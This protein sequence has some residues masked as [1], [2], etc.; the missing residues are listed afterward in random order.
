MGLLD[1]SRGGTGSREGS[2]SLLFAMPTHHI[3]AE[4]R[5]WSL[6]L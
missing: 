4:P 3:Q 1:C 6:R 5:Y 2:W